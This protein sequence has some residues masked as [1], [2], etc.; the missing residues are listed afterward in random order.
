MHRAVTVKAE[1]GEVLERVVRL[2]F[3]AVMQVYG[4]LAVR[5]AACLAFATGVL[6]A[7]YRTLTVLLAQSAHLLLVSWSAAG[8][9]AGEA[10]LLAPHLIL[11]LAGYVHAAVTFAKVAGAQHPWGPA[12][13]ANTTPAPLGTPFFRALPVG[14]QARFAHRFPSF[15]RGAAPHALETLFAEHRLDRVLVATKLAGYGHAALQFFVQAKGFVS[16]NF[17]QPFSG[18]V[19]T[20]PPACDVDNRS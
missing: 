16:V 6:P 11:R 19:G 2:I 15:G 1:A 13:N 17:Q 12:L 3:V 8:R 4:L 9:S 7:V 5:G 18:L 14:H 20:V 10:V